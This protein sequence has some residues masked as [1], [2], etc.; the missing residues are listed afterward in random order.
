MI[1]PV[2]LYLTLTGD[3]QPWPA[4][5]EVTDRMIKPLKWRQIDR[6]TDGRTDRQ[7]SLP[8]ALSPYYAKATQLI[9]ILLWF[10]GAGLLICVTVMLNMLEKELPIAQNNVPSVGVFYIISFVLIQFSMTISAITNNIANGLI[11]IRGPPSWIRHVSEDPIST[12]GATPSS[13]AI[14]LCVL[15]MQCMGYMLHFMWTKG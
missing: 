10:A 9:I 13:H 14:C 5:S 1:K 11:S 4:I 15:M 12:L 8:S 3:L 7:I 6:Q 2:L